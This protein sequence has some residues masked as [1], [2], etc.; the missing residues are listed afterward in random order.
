MRIVQVDADDDAALQAWHAAYSR[1][2]SHGRA[3]IATPWQLPEMRVTLGGPS[4][5]RHVRAYAGL[6]GGE[7]VTTGQLWLPLLDNLDKAEIH[8]DTPPEHRG[9]G[10]GTAMLA[11]LEHQAQERGRHRFVAEATWSYDQPADGH[12]S[13]YPRFLLDRGYDLGL[14]EVMRLLSLP[15]PLGRLAELTADAARHHSAYTLRSWVGA[16]PDDLLEGYAELDASLTTEA[17]QGTLEH[18]AGAVDLAAVREDEAKQV[19]QGRT[20]HSTVAL[21][22]AG[23]VVA[24]NDIFST[25]HE[26]HRGYQWGTLVAREHRGHRLGL[27]VKVA[28]IRLLQRNQPRVTTVRT[29]NA[30]SNSHMIGVNE[31]LGFCPV[32]RMGGFQRRVTPTR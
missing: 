20:R 13:A 19:E 18:E 5:R 29:W 27:G 25:V 4:R 6:A 11:H 30:E 32:E 21:D 22:E 23:Q 14:V 9:R 26:P 31:A 28:T 15:V 17:P 2:Q 24:Y 10:R 8:V 7:V 16:I 12:G 3:E 1:S